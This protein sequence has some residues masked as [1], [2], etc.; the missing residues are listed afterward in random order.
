M[1]LSPRVVYHPPTEQETDMANPTLQKEFGKLPPTN[2]ATDAALA[3]AQI[4]YETGVDEPMTI[5]GVAAK[6]AF[7]LILVVGA[8]SWG[9]SLVD[10]ASGSTS[11]P[12]WWF[13]ISFGV[14]ALA[15]LTVFKP[16]LAVVTG[17]LYAIT[18]GVA[19][20]SISRFYEAQ[21]EGIVIQALLAT[22]AVFIAM[23]VLFI[24]GTIKVTD[25][26]R[27]VVIGATFGILLLYLGSFLM[28][29][30]GWSSPVYSSGPVGIGFSLFIIAIA[31]LNL[32]IDF[33]M[34]VRGV[35]AR[36]PKYL[37]W[38]S[39]FGLMVTI[40]WLYIEILRLLGKV[41]N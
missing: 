34:V 18:Q 17:P 39:A 38:Y 30:F 19:I 27:G 14:L 10:P 32:M 33:D 41:R 21:F 24:T 35:N 40:V 7:L 25:K 23:L 20:G 6:T 36:A 1:I 37:E 16:R 12:V 8:G 15:I 5:G 29:L 22:V 28:S 11:L 31:A 2:A 4:P 13:F 3:T 26:F 9:W